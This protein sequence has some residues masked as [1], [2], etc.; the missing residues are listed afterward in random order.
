M[1]PGRTEFKQYTAF[2][3]VTYADKMPAL[4]DGRQAADY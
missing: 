4:R 1:I 3:F 2:P